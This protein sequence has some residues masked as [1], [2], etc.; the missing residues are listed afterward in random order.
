[1]TLRYIIEIIQEMIRSL[2][3][4]DETIMG[5]LFPTVPLR[6]GEDIRAAHELFV[7]VVFQEHSPPGFSPPF[8]HPLRARQRSLLTTS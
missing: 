5:V 6:S 1:M 8:P 7:D 4:S 3:M 2:G